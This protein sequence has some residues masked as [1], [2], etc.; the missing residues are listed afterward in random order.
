MHHLF[1]TASVAFLAVAGASELWAQDHRSVGEWSF[2]GD[3]IDRSGRGNGAFATAPV[4]A[5]GHSGQGL[6]CGKTA[7]MVPD[8]AELR[9]APGLRIECWAKFDT[10]GTSWQPLLMKTDAYQLRLDPPSEGGQFSFFLHLG[11]WEPRVRSKTVAKT[12][13]WYHLLAGWDGSE[14]WIEVDGQR[15]SQRRLGTPSPSSEPLEFG[16]FDGVLDDLR[17]DNPNA[18]FSGVAQWWFDGDLRDSSGHGHDLTGKDASFVPV[19]GGQALKSGASGFQAA[20]HPELQLSPGFRVDCSV[21]FEQVPTGGSMIAIKDGEYQLRVNPAKEGGAFAFFVNLDGWEPR[22]CSD[23]PV[24]PG[25]WYRLIARWDGSALTLDVDGRRK[26]LARSGLPKPAAHSLVIGGPGGRIDNLKIENPRLPGLQMRGA[27]QEHAI[28]CAGRPERLSTSIRNIGAATGKVSVRFELPPGTR[29]VGSPA[30]ELGPM[31]TGAER[32]IEWTVAADKPCMGDAEIRVTAADSP[33]VTARHPLVFFPSEERLPASA[34]ERSAKLPTGESQAVVYYVDSEAGNNANSGTSP[35]APWKDFTPVNGRKLGPGEKLLIRRGSILNQE[36]TVSAHGTE[37]RWAEIGAY[38]TGARPI[39][40]R[41][42]DIGD[43]CVLIQN[44]DF[45]RISGLVV[46]C[47][48][49]GLI[50]VYTEPGRRGLLI[51]DCIA[52]H[53]E[54]LYRPNSHGIPEW[55]DRGGCPGDGLSFSAGIAITGAPASDL[56]FR[57]CETYQCS[58]GY[59]VCGNDLLVDRVFCHDNIVHNTSPHPFA[60]EVRRAMLRN[61]IFDASGWHASAGTMGIMLGNPLG[62]IIR[63]CVFRNQPD[64]GSHDEGGVDFENSG[65]GCLIDQCTFENNAGAAI[66]VLGLQAPQTT[67]IEIRNSR[68]IQNNTAKKLGP[69]EI[70]IWGQVRDPSVCC[71]TGQI[72]GNGYVTRPGIEFYVNEAPTLTSWTLRDNRGY[73]TVKELE[74]AK[75]FNRPPVVETGADIRTDQRRVRLAG[76]ATDDGRPAEKQLATAWEVIEGPG[77]VTFEHAQ[78]PTTFATFQQPGDYLLR[79][80]A[81]DGEFWLGRLLTVH[82]LPAGTSVAA[83]WEFN[84]NLNKEGW[85]ELNTGTRTRE[86]PDPNWS[87]RSEP[88][89]YVA[90]GYYMV[91]VENSSDACLFSPDQL[92]INLVGHETITLRFQNHTTAGEMRLRFTTDAD[93]AWDEAKSQ[94]FKVAA[95]DNV[96]RTYTLNLST[97]PG[98]KGRLR[99]LRLDLAT[100]QPVTGTCR[101]DYVWITTTGERR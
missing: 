37:N 69:A 54:G 90:G 11:Q 68:F 88:V 18:R 89:K 9:P 73:A 55:R 44:P 52:H 56:V 49:K 96:C 47:A 34:S 57:N 101:F 21:Y 70:Y 93:G 26:R 27:R 76:K 67:N 63:D 64:S 14:I 6:R 30:Q 19:P 53:I 87:T 80:T 65:N 48:G 91:A 84:T 83:A 78:S 75:P 39:I 86:W 81:D 32:T 82:I 4:F 36:L 41:N 79:L 3:L 25:R 28:L 13:V 66:E 92:G 5:P 20:S 62:L 61:C 38:G 29:L 8:S 100:G 50:V 95:Q 99:Q 98:W 94:V 31:P 24:L 1:M 7:V 46:C 23:E 2:D 16:Q 45:L 15:A 77:A 40:R 51:E 35:A 60:V 85:T 33:L 58:S 10:L 43:R 71:S 72:Q 74:L 59:F 42:W 97:V 12:G 17:I 22:V